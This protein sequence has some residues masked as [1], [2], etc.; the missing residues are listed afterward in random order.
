MP[1]Q[2]AA[3]AMEGT[4]KRRPRERWRDQVQEVLDVMGITNRQAIARDRWEWGK[5][6]L[7]AKV[8]SGLRWLRGSRKGICK[9]CLFPNSG[10]SR[11]HR[12]LSKTV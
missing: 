3:L 6:M 12:L 5:I 1:K 2:F 8:Y 4:R 10:I 7:E 9:Q 11:S